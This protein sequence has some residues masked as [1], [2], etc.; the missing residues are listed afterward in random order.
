[1]DK[2]RDANDFNGLRFSVRE[3]LTPAIWRRKTPP[4]LGD[5]GAETVFRGSLIRTGAYFAP[6]WTW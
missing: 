3:T 2:V 4:T 1:M 5:G 6:G